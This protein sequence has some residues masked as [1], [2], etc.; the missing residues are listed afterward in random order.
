MG[1]ALRL[2]A[3]ALAVALAGGS[4]QAS[5]RRPAAPWLAGRDLRAAG[6]I[7]APASV[8]RDCR[9]VAAK[10]RAQRTDLT[11]YCPAA[12]PDVLPIR[13]ELAC[14]VRR[15]SRLDEGYLVGFWAPSVR[16][17]YGW[18]GHWT[19]G[20]GPAEALRS[21]LGGPAP[22]RRVELAGLPVR[23]SFIPQRRAAFS[24][25]HIVAE[26]RQQGTTFHLTAHGLPWERRVRAM[27][28]ILID[29]IRR[30]APGRRERPAACDRVVFRSR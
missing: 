1:S 8:R 28:A 18:G 13:L 6:L 23:L 24:A 16:W 17:A 7:A 22:S 3:V 30:C 29:Q 11:V 2:A 10:A 4:A 25:G 14:G 20:A 15:C 21:W 19:V 27:T 9:D 26:W 12:V 5:E